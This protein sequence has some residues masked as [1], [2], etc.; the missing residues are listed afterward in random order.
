[1]EAERVEG[2][3]LSPVPAKKYL[4]TITLEKTAGLSP[5][6]ANF[7]PGSPFSPRRTIVA[8]ILPSNSNIQE[9]EE[10]RG[11][12]AHKTVSEEEKG[13]DAHDERKKEKDG[14][15]RENGENPSGDEFTLEFLFQEIC[16]AI[17]E[18]RTERVL[19]ILTGEYRGW[20]EHPRFS[21]WV[22][23]MMKKED[24]WFGESLLHLATSNGADGSVIA[25]LLQ[26]GADVLARDKHGNR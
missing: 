6:Q 15:A 14:D 23:V 13:G 8:N 3:H 25:I 4:T 2:V 18:E 11:D 9:A 1:M 22:G 24:D 12:E 17:R 7:V 19:Q 20:K 21:E 5:S 16:N 10:E 26:N